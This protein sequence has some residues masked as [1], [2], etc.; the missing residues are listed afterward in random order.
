[1]PSLHHTRFSV[2]VACMTL[3][4]CGGGKDADTP[5]PGTAA[6][7]GAATG[8][9]SLNVYNWS[10]YID[11][12]VLEQFRKET[13]ITVNYDVFD[14]NEVLETKLLTGKSGYDIV[15]PSAYFLERQVAAGVFAPID[16]ARLPNLKNLD[17]EITA[18]AARHDAGNA[19]S[20]VYM[21]GTTGIG[22]DAA[23]V[24]AILPDAP[25]DSWKLVFDPAILARFKDCG[26]SM[27]DDPT[28]MV[29]TALL[30]LGKD[31][32]SEAPA[33]LAAAE[34]LLLSIRPYLRTIHSSQYIDQL[35]NGELCIA[36]GYSGDILQARDRA[37]EAGKPIEIAYS[38]PKEGALLWFDTLAIPAD[39]PHPDNA[40]K[41][42]DF[43]LRPEVAAANSNFVMYANPNAAATPLLDEGLRDD[44]GIYPTPEVKA[45]LRANLAKSPEF[46]RELN[47]TW[48]RF[49][50]GR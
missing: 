11:P 46:T 36:V 8:P 16:A 42:I 18:Q 28:D 26:V 4:A 10:D 39:A 44:P 9:A 21:W 49:T 20:V 27:L 1:M 45:R 48:T 32:N 14:S 35:A 37:E 50:T 47:R 43:L 34:K 41:F 13:G 30:Y 31:P 33:D 3:V 5:P 17:P 24:K 25:V 12:A 40:Y 29:A 2:L 38:I 7:P 6:K 19:H 15:V 22:Y 23:K